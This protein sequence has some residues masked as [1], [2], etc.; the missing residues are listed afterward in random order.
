MA[1]AVGP[2][3]VLSIFFCTMA[4]T[5]SV[6]RAV[7][8]CGVGG[9][10]RRW[11][12]Q[13]S[14][15]FLSLRSFLSSSPLLSSPL[16]V[17]P[18]HG[19]H[20]RYGGDRGRRHRRAAQRALVA[21]RVP[22]ARPDRNGLGGP[23]ARHDAAERERGRRDAVPRALRRPRHECAPQQQVR[24]R[25][26]VPPGRA[27]GA[28]PR[29]GRTGRCQRLPQCVQQE[30]RHCP[31]RVPRAAART[32]WAVPT[33]PLH[34]RRR[35]DVFP[36]RDPPARPVRDPHPRRGLER[37]VDRLPARAA[38]PPPPPPRAE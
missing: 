23:P 12:L 25:T 4:A 29:T 11:S 37:K 38:S 24:A 5:L 19:Q 34:E 2:S 16:L 32:A 10:W 1:E 33:V 30:R 9:V 27:R 17:L 8:A 6:S 18:S 3:N 28:Y 22:R 31:L 13:L 36:S 21:A 7:A 14:C 15:L 26:L 20:G 35:L